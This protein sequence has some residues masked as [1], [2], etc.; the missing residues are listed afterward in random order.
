MNEVDPLSMTLEEIYEQP[1]HYFELYTTPQHLPHL[2]LQYDRY[3]GH[4]L[5]NNGTKIFTIK[6]DDQWA[7]Y[8]NGEHSRFCSICNMEGSEYLYHNKLG[9]YWFQEHTGYVRPHP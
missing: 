2:G 8:D 4:V 9:V 7:A 1:H 3:Y 6:E 5:R